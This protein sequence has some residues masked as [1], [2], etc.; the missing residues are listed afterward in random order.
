[1]YEIKQ[2]YI[3]RLRSFLLNE[4]TLSLTEDPE[5]YVNAYDPNVL[6]G[7]LVWNYSAYLA[8]EYEFA[9]VTAVDYFVIPVF[10]IKEDL[11]VCNAIQYVGINIDMYRPLDQT[12]QRL[13]IVAQN[14]ADWHGEL[15]RTGVCPISLN[16]DTEYM[17][18][19]NGT[20]PATHLQSQPYTR[21]TLKYKL[22]VLHRI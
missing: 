17:I 10:G 19:P 9:D 4:T 22:D 8:K 20:T 3:T 15:L 16:V 13:D 18:L 2:D 1:M 5:H 21:A 6:Q 7:F 12:G 14:I 11:T